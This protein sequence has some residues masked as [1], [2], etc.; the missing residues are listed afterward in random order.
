MRALTEITS[1]VGTN[2]STNPLYAK[3]DTTTVVVKSINNPESFYA[4]FNETLGYFLAGYLEIPVPEFGFA[5]FVEGETKNRITD[6]VI[7]DN[8][9]FFTFTK[10]ENSIV[11]VDNP[12]LVDTISD[13][14]IIKLIIFDVFI[15]N[16]DR[17][18]G[19]LLLKMP[20]KGKRASLFPIDY[21]HIFP[22][23]CL[24]FDILSK[25]LPSI[26]KI[27][28]EVFTV[29][30]HQK[31][32]EN[33]VFSN[34]VVEQTANEFKINLLNIDIDGIISSI[35]EILR[36][37][38]NESDIQNLKSYLNRNREYLDDIIIEIKKYLVR[39]EGCTKSNMQV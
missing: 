9:E 18:K 8:G 12:A 32:I 11:Q 26:D 17:N 10:M 15:S 19:N 7:F 16:T 2:F 33:R 14:D 27:V 22:G 5:K 31:L 34:D 36:K 39:W 29:G 4:L 25:P 3:L 21:T 13:N 30:G 24:W 37:K 20:K 28:E 23:E 38:H 6:D 35:P 1:R